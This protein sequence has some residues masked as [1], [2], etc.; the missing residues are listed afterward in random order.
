M[1]L[2][3]EVIEEKAEELNEA[4]AGTQ[5]PQ[6]AFKHMD[7]AYDSV[8]NAIDQLGQAETFM[9]KSGLKGDFEIIFAA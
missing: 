3:K 6:I 2:L 1:S 5:A 8:Q 9:K 4:P 7:K